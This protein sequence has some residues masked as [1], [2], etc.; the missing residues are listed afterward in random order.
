MPKHAKIRDG[1]EIFYTKLAVYL[2]IFKHKSRENV[3]EIF[4]VPKSTLQ[5]WVKE[6][7]R[8]RLEC[9]LKNFQ[10]GVGGEGETPEAGGDTLGE[11]RQV[12]MRQARSG[13]VAAA[14][15]VMELER[16]EGK[17]D[18]PELTVE[19]AIELLRQ[20]DAPRAC[21]QCGHV[22]EFKYEALAPP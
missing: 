5:N 10:L 9:I 3:G 6:Y 14:K 15:M 4:G 12:L 22:D 17:S 1:K 11:M 20:W 18:D 7:S 2:H 19:G 8:S 13:S 16:E 21:P